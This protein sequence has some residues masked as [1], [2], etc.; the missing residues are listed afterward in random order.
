MYFYPH[1]VDKGGGGQISYQIEISPEFGSFSGAFLGTFDKNEK[2]LWYFLKIRELF[3]S[4][5]GCF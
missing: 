4:F 1:F 2:V 5:F 3:G